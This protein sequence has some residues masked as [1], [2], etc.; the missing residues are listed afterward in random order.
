MAIHDD[1][2]FPTNIS[3]G[4]LGGPEFLTDVVIADGGAEQRTQMWSLA[5]ERWNVAY[6]VR[7]QA[8]LQALLTFFYARKGRLH[9][10]RFK[11][12]DD[13][14]GVDE[15]VGDGDGATAV[16]QLIKTYTSGTNSYVR[17]INYP[18]EDNVDV[19]IKI[20]GTPLA[21]SG[22]ADRCDGPEWFC[23]YLFGFIVLPGARLADRFW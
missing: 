3:Y 22:P 5:R 9:A 15:F 4:S 17:T 12:H 16:W 1:V 11:N 23:L 2:R 18:T 6:G 20:N 10:F 7:E 21:R 13:Y 19:V 8:D 14:Q